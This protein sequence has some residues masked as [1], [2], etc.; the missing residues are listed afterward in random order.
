[1][2]EAVVEAVKPRGASLPATRPAT[3]I[4]AAPIND[5]TIAPR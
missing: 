4:N 2:H 1:M 5:A 3:D